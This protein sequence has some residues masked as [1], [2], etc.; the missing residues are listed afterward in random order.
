MADVQQYRPLDLEAQTDYEGLSSPKLI[1]AGNIPLGDDSTGIGQPYFIVA[2]DYIAVVGS[3]SKVI[4]M[5]PKYGIGLQGPISLA[6][7]PDQIS[8]SGGY[9]RINPLVLSTLPSTSATPIPWLVKATPAILQGSNDL[10]SIVSS[11][12]SALG[13][14]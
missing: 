2:E 12:E 10:A 9:W 1:Y 6:A 7:N 5:S 14:S 8:L 3:S 13:I 4:G 11:V